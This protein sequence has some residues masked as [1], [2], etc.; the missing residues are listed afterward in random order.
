MVDV[1]FI[2]ANF[3]AF[4]PFTE[5]GNEGDPPTLSGHT[6][7]PFQKVVIRRC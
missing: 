3:S 6:A 4:S 1:G 7:I 2:E 5:D